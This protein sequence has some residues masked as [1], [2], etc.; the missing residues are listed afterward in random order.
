MPMLKFSKLFLIFCLIC[1]SSVA[2]AKTL[3][4]LGDS[5]S[6]AYGMP[7]ESGWVA[8]LTARLQQKYPDWSVINASISGET[9][10]GGLTRLKSLLEQHTPNLVVIELGAND[11]LR[12]LALSDMKSNLQAM[13][14]QSVAINAKIVMF[15]MKLPPNYGV[16]FASLFE[17]VYVDIVQ[18]NTLTFVP[19][20]LDGVA[21]HPELTQAD[22]LHPVASAEPTIL[23][24]VWVTLDK[25]IQKI[26]SEKQK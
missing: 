12:G 25:S 19:F 18:K 23:E 26:N 17:K 20:F 14:D 5:L 13:I 4:V 15:G 9:T 10:R 22:G 11:G 8:L 24:N 3:L 6:A 2:N 1:L 21:G 7:V 16:K